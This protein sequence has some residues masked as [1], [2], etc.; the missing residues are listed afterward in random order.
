MVNFTLSSCSIKARFFIFNQPRTCPDAGLISKSGEQIKSDNNIFKGSIKRQPH[1]MLCYW[2]QADLEDETLNDI[3]E[4]SRMSNILFVPVSCISGPP[5]LFAIFFLCPFSFL[6]QSVDSCEDCL[7]RL[8]SL[9]EGRQLS[10]VSGHRMRQ[11]ENK[12]ASSL[13]LPTSQASM[14]G[15]PTLS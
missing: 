15:L 14:G 4:T 8:W 11:R 12:V 6:S 5:S 1:P 13:C 3:P 2:C 10:F 7:H 9:A